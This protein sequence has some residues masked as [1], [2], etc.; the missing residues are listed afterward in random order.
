MAPVHCLAEEARF[1][2]VKV[3]NN[4]EFVFYVRSSLADWLYLLIVDTQSLS[5]EL[6]VS[7]FYFP[8]FANHIYF[9]CKHVCSLVHWW[10][11]VWG[12]VIITWDDHCKNCSHYLFLRLLRLFVLY[13]KYHLWHYY[14]QI[15]AL[16]IQNSC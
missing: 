4:W 5:L 10:N 6:E 14:F 8:L 15:Q 12:S 7:N 13:G 1:S 2:N 16:L 11:A 3:D 9:Y